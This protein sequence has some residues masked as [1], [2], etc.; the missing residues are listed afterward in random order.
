MKMNKKNVKI[1]TILIVLVSICA[2]FSLLLAVVNSITAPIIEARSK[3]NELSAYE[4]VANGYEIS[5]SP[6]TVSDDSNVKL[7][8]TMKNGDETAYILNIK[9]KG[10]GGEFSIAASYKADG[11]LIASKMLENSETPGLGKKSEESWY[12]ELFTKSGTIPSS[13]S[14]LSDED[15]ALVSGASVTFQAI[16]NALN[17]GQAWV[18]NNLSG[19]N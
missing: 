17:E 1:T 13:K 12:M 2:I 4:E 11:S 7:Y 18:I 9:G 3:G 10:Y 15:A 5:N 8:Y 19:K 6:N 14:S 16:C